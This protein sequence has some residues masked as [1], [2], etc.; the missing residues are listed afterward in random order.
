MGQFLQTNGDYNI[1]TREGGIVRL[2]VGP[3][4]QADNII[5]PIAISA[6]T[7]SNTINRYANN[8]NRIIWF[9]KPTKIARGYFK[10]L[11]KSSIVSD[12]PIPIMI[13]KRERANA[14]VAELS[15]NNKC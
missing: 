8:G 12:K 7:L 1:K 10:I 13:I 3:P 9:K 14:I 15:I 6:S 4:G 2:D 11:L 5:N